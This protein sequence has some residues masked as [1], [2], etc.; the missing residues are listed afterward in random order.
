MQYLTQIQ[1]C[2]FLHPEYYRYC[3]PVENTCY[4]YGFFLI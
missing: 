3:L 4:I 1:M 2:E